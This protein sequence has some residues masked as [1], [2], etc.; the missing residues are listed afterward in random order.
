[1][2]KVIL[3]FLVFLQLFLT[4]IHAQ[5]TADRWRGSN[6]GQRGGVITIPVV[7]H[8]LYNEESENIPDLQVYSQLEVLNEDFRLLNENVL[9][10]ASS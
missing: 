1:M 10:V 9:V 8:I 7:V 4:D 5:I 6:A 3:F 2:R